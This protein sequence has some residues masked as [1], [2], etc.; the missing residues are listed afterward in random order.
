[1]PDLGFDYLGPQYSQRYCPAILIGCESVPI[2]IN[3]W[4]H[5]DRNYSPK[6]IYEK[7]KVNDWW[8]MNDGTALSLRPI[9]KFIRFHYRAIHQAI[10]T[11]HYLGLTFKLLRVRWMSMPSPDI[12]RSTCSFGSEYEERLKLLLFS[13]RN[14]TEST[15]SANI[16]R[17][18]LI[19]GIVY[20]R[21]GSNT[22]IFLI[23]DSQSEKINANTGMTWVSWWR[24]NLIYRM[25]HLRSEM[26]SEIYTCWHKK[27]NAKSAREDSV[28]QRLN[29]RSIKR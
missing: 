15:I 20:R 23:R 25:L 18:C 10:S 5:G 24:E 21:C 7:E 11:K 2:I 12:S 22:N 6:L 13:D 14:A 16:Q 1:M 27:R 17:C 28:T 9:N 4:L 19:C 8:M 3:K 29:G 26:N